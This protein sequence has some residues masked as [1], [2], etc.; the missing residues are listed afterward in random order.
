[1]LQNKSPYPKKKPWRLARKASKSAYN[2]IVL[3]PMCKE[4]HLDILGEKLVMTLFS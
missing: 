1:M 2:C 4:N 3:E